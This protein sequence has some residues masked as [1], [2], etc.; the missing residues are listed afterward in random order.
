MKKILVLLFIVG[1]II[2]MSKLGDGE[3]K[4][5]KDMIRNAQAQ[6]EIN[7]NSKK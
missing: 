6:R 5:N 7:I 3:T 2:I 4:D 1:T